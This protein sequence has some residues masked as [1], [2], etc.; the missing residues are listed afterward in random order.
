MATSVRGSLRYGLLRLTCHQYSD[1]LVAAEEI[2]VP[3]PASLAHVVCTFLPVSSV[4]LGLSIVLEGNT[5]PFGIKSFLICLPDGAI[6]N[7]KVITHTH[8]RHF[9]SQIGI[10]SQLGRQ[11]HTS[12]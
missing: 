2:S 11:N 1:S 12:L 4:C 8:N 10:G 6:P 3:P 5:S 7:F 9:V